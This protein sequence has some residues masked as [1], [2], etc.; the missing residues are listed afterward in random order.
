MERAYD[1]RP[2]TLERLDEAEASWRASMGDD[3]FD[4]EF[5][6]PY[7]YARQ[8]AR[9]EVTLSSLDSANYSELVNLSS[10][11]TVALVDLVQAHQGRQMKL[12]HFHFGP[13]LWDY[14]A[15]TAGTVPDRPR[16]ALIA[17]MAHLLEHARSSATITGVRVYGRSEEH[18]RI[19]TQVAKSWPSSGGV[20]R[21]AMKGRWLE[22]LP[23]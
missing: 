18:H 2:V 14:D 12:L 1:L 4:M 9:E 19:L 8:A 5:A 23:V 15:G 11:E 21:A 10:G 22:F 16:D 3:L 6:Q 20:W 17:I 13:Q 7:G